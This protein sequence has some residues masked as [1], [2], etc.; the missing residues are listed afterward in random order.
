MNTIV[1]IDDTNADD[2]VES[3]EI[4]LPAISV[5]ADLAQAL[6]QACGAVEALNLDGFNAYH[7]YHYPTIAQVR[8]RARQA[9]VEA[10]IVF[11]P[12]IVRVGRVMRQTQ[13]GKQIKVTVV[14]VD[15][16]LMHS[17]GQVVSRRWIGESEDVGDKGVQ[18]A[19]SAAIKSF[20]INTLLM[21]VVEEENDDGSPEEARAQA[22]Q[23]PRQP[24]PPRQ[25]M[26]QP[27]QPQP[28]P[29]PSRPQNV[30]SPAEVK[31]FI[32]DEV[33]GRPGAQDVPATDKQCGLISRLVS[34]AVGGNDDK[35]HTVLRYLLG[36]ESTSEL[37]KS[38]AFAVLAWLLDPNAADGEEKYRLHPAAG[39]EIGEILREAA[40]ESGQLEPDETAI[41]R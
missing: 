16:A 40:R 24:Q 28:Q 14:E 25:A 41:L 11:L 9:F 20:L 10:Q 17:S 33:T 29:R 2:N 30:M 18:K 22:V 26:Q 38:E 8:E 7:R 34:K 4:E 39:S 21:P 35:C 6:A 37:S 32:S 36:K 5:G 12:G 27:R 13:D 1:T 31:Q 19:A 3:V 23:Q 15:C